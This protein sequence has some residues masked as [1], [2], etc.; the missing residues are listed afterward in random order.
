[1][2]PSE[3]IRRESPG[4]NGVSRGRGAGECSSGFPLPLGEGQGEG[5]RMNKWR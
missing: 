2:F 5:R 1:V 4:L 3:G